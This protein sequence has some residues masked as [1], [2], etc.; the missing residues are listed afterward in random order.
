MD[1]PPHAMLECLSRLVI[2]S[3]IA[4]SKVHKF[5][6]LNRCRQNCKDVFRHGAFAHALLSALERTTSHPRLYQADA[7]SSSIS[8]LKCCFPSKAFHG[9][10]QALS[11][12]PLHSTPLFRELMTVHLFAACSLLRLRAPGRQGQACLVLCAIPH[13]PHCWAHSRRS[14]NVCP[15]NKYGRKQNKGFHISFCLLSGWIAKF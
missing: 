7:F 5:F 14:I 10:S 15:M 1:V 11:P 3:G 12:E 2:R 13:L 8:Q 9:L 4:D 6:I